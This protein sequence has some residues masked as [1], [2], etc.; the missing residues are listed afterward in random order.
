MTTKAQNGGMLRTRVLGITVAAATQILFAYT[1]WRL[2]WF[3][4]DGTPTT[5]DASLSWDTA[6]A[7]QFALPHSILLMPAVKARITK[8]LPTAFYGLMFCAVTCMSLLAAVRFWQGHATTVWELHGTAR[9]LTL[10]GFAASWVALYY[11]ISIT[12][13]GYQTG[14]TPWTFWLRGMTPP[15]RGLAD[16]GAYRL[17]R[18]PV[19]LSFL[20]MIWFT[21]RM[22]LDHALLTAIWTAY[23]YVGSWLK[24][25]RLAFYLGDRYLAYAARVPGYPLITLGPLGRYRRTSPGTGLP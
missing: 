6:L 16:R 7:L 13:L 3:L 11:S 8:I 2:F 12:G 19:Y 5:A 1:V 18:H 9:S 23:I 4:K 17:L 22:T 10:I 25:R 21:P 24:D 14:Y 20:G 15:P